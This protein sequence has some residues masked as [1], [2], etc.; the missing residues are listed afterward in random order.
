MLLCTLILTLSS[1]KRDDECIDPDDWGGVQN[2]TV[3]SFGSSRSVHEDDGIQTIDWQQ[4]PKLDG[5]RVV[6]EVRNIKPQ[7]ARKYNCQQG[8][9][10]NGERVQLFTP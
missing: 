4:G 6:M 1:C 5:N 7:L 2:L 8:V 9:D 3:S 10:E